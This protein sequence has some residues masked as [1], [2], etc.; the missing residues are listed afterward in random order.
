MDTYGEQKQTELDL[1]DWLQPAGITQST[2]ATDVQHDNI[3]VT[4]ESAN[5]PLTE[6]CDK[7][8]QQ[9]LTTA[10]A[11]AATGVIPESVDES[12]QV[13]TAAGHADGDIP[14]LPSIGVFLSKTCTI[15][16][17][18][19]DFEQI[20]ETVEQQTLQDKGETVTSDQT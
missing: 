2:F 7:T 17:I 14:V 9:A 4:P 12:L 18:R 19:C 6:E 5:A 15:P 16:L 20:K 3:D 8:R 11:M 13:E 10:G 1:S